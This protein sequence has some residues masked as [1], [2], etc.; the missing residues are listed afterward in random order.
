[1]RVHEQDFEH[2]SSQSNQPK[3]LHGNKPEMVQLILARPLKLNLKFMLLFSKDIY[4]DTEKLKLS[5]SI[6]KMQLF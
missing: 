4:F 2:L 1:M 5:I 3:S 6:D